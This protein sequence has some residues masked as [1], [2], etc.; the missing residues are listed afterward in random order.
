VNLE[1]DNLNSNMDVYNIRSEEE[2]RQILDDLRQELGMPVSLMD[3][4]NVI[5]QTSGERNVLCSAIRTVKESLISICSQTQQ[6][7]TKEVRTTRRPFIGACE[8]GMSKLV[9]PIFFKGGWVGTITACGACI[10]GEEIE[11]FMVE[12]SLQMR[13]EEISRLAK[14]VPKQEQDKVVEVAN[15]VFQELHENTILFSLNGF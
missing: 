8:V 15:R 6:F 5:L 12:K 2:W 13:E 11:T 4:E 14:Q 1:P 10:P 3:K 9:I 7:M